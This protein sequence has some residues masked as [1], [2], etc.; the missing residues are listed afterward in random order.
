MINICK[1]SVQFVTSIFL[2][3]LTLKYILGQFMRT[4]S[5]ICAQFA[6]LFSQKAGFKTHM[7]SVHE[8]KYSDMNSPTLFLH[9]NCIT[10]GKCMDVPFC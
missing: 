1:R 8:N 10:F 6:I 3:K 5:H 2:K 7:E 9:I 4:K